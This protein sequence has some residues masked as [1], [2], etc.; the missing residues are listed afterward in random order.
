MEWQYGTYG[1]GI[2]LSGISVFDI[3]GDRKL[4][5]VMGGSTSTFGASSFWYVVKYSMANTYQQ[6]WISDLYYPA[7]I[8]RIAVD[9][10]D[11]DGIGEIYIGFSNGGAKVYDGYT[12]Q[13][14]GS[15][16]VGSTIVDLVVADADADGE[17]GDRHHRWVE[18]L[19]LFCLTLNPKWISSGYGGTSIAVG[20]VDSDPG[21]EIV[22]TNN[23][24]VGHGYV[25]DGVTHA[26]KWDYINS[27]GRIVKLGD[28]DSDGRQEIVGAASWGKITIFDAD[29]KTPTWEI[30]TAQDIGAL[31]VADTNG[32]GIPEILYGDGQWGKIRCYD[33][34]TKARTM[35]Y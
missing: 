22:V 17:N 29:I 25:I 1:S 26:L 4:E 27:F 5:M 16:M 9:D 6:V 19:C 24:Y 30:T 12:F 18:N 15:F 14:I 28:L 34:V 21:P 10:A 33:A 2:G 20:N 23:V 7:S 35:G 3:D 13:E 32:D 31:A 11:G 8:S